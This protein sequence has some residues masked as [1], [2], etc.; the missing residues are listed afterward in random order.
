MGDEGHARLRV[1]ERLQITDFMAISI[2]FVVNT[3]VVLG[4]AFVGTTPVS[5]AMVSSLQAL[6]LGILTVLF[7]SKVRKPVMLLTLL[8]ES[9]ASIEPENEAMIQKVISR[10]IENKRVLAIAHELRSMEAYS[11]G[12]KSQSSPFVIVPSAGIV[13]NSQGSLFTAQQDEEAY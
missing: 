5:H 2:F 8:D 12:A 7:Y 13:N 6:V 4:T 11:W 3:P 1:F 10:L 9:T